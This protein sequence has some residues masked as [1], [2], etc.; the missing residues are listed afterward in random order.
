MIKSVVVVEDDRGLREE[1]INLLSSAP[2]VDCI[3]A[4]ASAEEALRRIPERWPD[5]VLMD[6]GLPGMSGIDCVGELKR[7]NPT[8]QIIMVTVYEDSERIFK[9]LMA[10]ANGYLVKSKSTEHLLDAVRD[11][12]SGGAPMS[13]QIARKVVQHF[14]DVSARSREKSALSPKEQKVLALLAEGYIYKEIGDELKIGAETVRS[15]V[16]HICQKLHVRNR[17]EAVA[18]HR[19]GF[20]E[21]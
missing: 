19:F 16:K 10:G 3:G 17:L 7:R 1:L 20:S 8:L 13:S 18:K 14:H 11:L 2:D 5:V 12:E 21:G 6:I 4:F 9:A 15:H